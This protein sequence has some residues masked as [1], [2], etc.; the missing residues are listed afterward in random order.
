MV[1]R[2]F[3]G[4]CHTWGRSPVTLSLVGDGV[5]RTPHT[6]T[7]AQHTRHLHQHYHGTMH[8]DGR[9]KYLPVL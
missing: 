5:L 6:Y 8:D 1:S 3:W 9:S 2:R 4:I 7:D